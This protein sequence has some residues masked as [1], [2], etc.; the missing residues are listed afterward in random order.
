MVEGPVRFKSYS[1]HLSRV[2]RYDQDPD[3]HIQ[4]LIQ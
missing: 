4:T 1:F 2:Q 3:A